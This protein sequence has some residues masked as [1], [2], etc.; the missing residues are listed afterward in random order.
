MQF[1]EKLTSKISAQVTDS[2]E[3]I[4]LDGLT[5]AAT[6]P[7]NAKAQMDKILHIVNKAVN[8]SGMIRTITQEATE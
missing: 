1:T 5:I 3:K 6:T 4:T 8:T 7:E 2:T